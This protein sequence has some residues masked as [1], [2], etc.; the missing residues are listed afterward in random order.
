MKYLACIFALI[1]LAVM[2]LL[3]VRLDGST[4]ILFSFVGCPAL[5]IALALYAFSRWR[6][7]AFRV[8]E[9]ASK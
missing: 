4:A 9:P 3:L 5:G 2:M 6:E 1:A 8:D 7:G